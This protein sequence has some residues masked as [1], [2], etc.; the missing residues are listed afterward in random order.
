[1]RL[2]SQ[3]LLKMLVD[4]HKEDG[5]GQRAIAARAGISVGYLSHLLAGRKTGVSYDVAI[6]LAG[7]LGVAP[8]VLFALPSST[9]DVRDAA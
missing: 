3:Q 6:G 9:Q 8:A 1:M 7:S 4:L 5:R 2:R